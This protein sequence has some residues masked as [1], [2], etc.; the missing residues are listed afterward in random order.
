MSARR[1]NILFIWTDEQRP[2]TIGAYETTEHSRSESAGRQ[3]AVGIKTPN[4]DALAAR[5]T[6]F[7]QAYCTQ[8][9]CSPSRASVLTGL[10][11]HSHG[12]LINNMP[13]SPQVPTLAEL[14]RPHGYRSGYVGK[15]HL[16]N[17]I[18]AQRGFEDT[19]VSIE[20][21]YSS[22]PDRG[23]VSSYHH[24]LVSRGY[25]PED[26]RPGAKTFGRGVVARLP[27][28]VGKPAFM[29]GEVCGF[30]DRQHGAQATGSDQPF[31]LVVNFLEPHMP[32]F[33]PLDDLYDPEAMTLPESWY[34]ELEDTVPERYRWA[35]EHYRQHNPHLTGHQDHLPP[36]QRRPDVDDEIGWKRLKARYW[37]LCTLVDKYVGV[38]M[39]R[40]EALGM[41]E[42]TIVVYSTD[43]GDMMGEHHLIAKELQYE[44]AVHVP[45]IVCE[46]GLAPQRVSAPV[47][48]ID[49]VPTL[50]E[51]VGVP[52]PAHLQGAS[53]R[54]LM[55][56][57]LDAPS[58]QN[59][60]DIVIEWNGYNGRVPRDNPGKLD[61]GDQH[62]RIAGVD[63]RTIRRGRWKLNVHL[64]GEYELY[65]LQDD[66]GERH[67]AAYDPNQSSVVSELLAG[68][69]A[70]QHRTG[71]TLALPEPH[72]VLA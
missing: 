17:E 46:P 40:L 36:E 58:R 25:R 19:W 16:G 13:L 37:G 1:K 66:P 42:D 34:S 41:A 53:L 50:L 43:H 21:G 31:L 68:L 44:G 10:Y 33:G 5:G 29:A 60:A 61:P 71:D 6:L 35:R 8:P 72:R 27:E 55:T 32:F 24:F 45:L 2:D 65:D 64:T 59:S 39:L 51:A 23:R 14:L 63:V 47:S 9:V 28:E 30:L 57:E 15:W 38:I 52:A 67:N 20:D 26:L 56:G 48:Q 69:R 18:E 4:V 62:V 7:E 11:P 12:V 54:P 22:D 70:W 49:L 3:G